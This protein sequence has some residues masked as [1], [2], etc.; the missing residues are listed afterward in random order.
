[1]TMDTAWVVKA[2]E[3]MKFDAIFDSLA[4]SG[5]FL[6]GDKVKPVLLNSKLPVDVLGRVWELSDIDRDGMLDR[7]E[8]A[9]RKKPPV[10]PGM[11]LLPSPP[12][13][14]DA[15]SAHS[16]GSKGGGHHAP[17]PPP[18]APAPAPTPA[19]APW[20]VSPADKAMYDELFSKT[21][22]DMDGLVSGPE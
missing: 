18:P 13:T 6:T 8:F 16:A 22:G 2:E 21:D 11:P 10:P 3:K 1:M 20:V 4:P 7:D 17:K 12:S 14:K 15:R 9:V 5:G 19:A